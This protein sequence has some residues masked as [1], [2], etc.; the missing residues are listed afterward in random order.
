MDYIKENSLKK[1]TSTMKEKDLDILVFDFVKVY[2]DEK[3]V[4]EKS[5]N[6]V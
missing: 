4:H 5:M 2:N 3:F 6:N 1:L